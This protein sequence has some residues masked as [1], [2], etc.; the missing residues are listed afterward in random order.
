VPNTF[1]TQK[2]VENTAATTTRRLL[3]TPHLNVPE[4]SA[5]VRAHTLYS[6]IL[7]VDQQDSS[8]AYVDCEEL[9][10]SVYIFGSRARNRALDGDEVAVELVDVDEMMNEK[11]AKRQARRTRRLSAMSL[12]GS[13]SFASNGGLS[14]IPEDDT[15]FDEEIVGS[16]PKYCGKVACILERPR[17]MLFSG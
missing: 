8:E 12:N 5:L 14:S 13:L 2:P 15:F 10:G 6:G 7:R 3:Y 16:R 17:N 9:D 11:Q 4:A 1:L